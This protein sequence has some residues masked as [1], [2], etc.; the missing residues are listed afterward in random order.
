MPGFSSV[1]EADSLAVEGV[2]VMVVV[3]MVV[4]VVVVVIKLWWPSQA[5][6]GLASDNHCHHDSDHDLPSIATVMQVATVFSPLVFNV[7]AV[8]R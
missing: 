7:D 4:V 1:Q 6:A 5:F 3:V 2:V 8:V